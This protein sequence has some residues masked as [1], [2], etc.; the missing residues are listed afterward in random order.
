MPKDPPSSLKTHKTPRR[1]GGFPK[2]PAL[3]KWDVD[4]GPL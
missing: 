3:K 1:K 2:E 4:T